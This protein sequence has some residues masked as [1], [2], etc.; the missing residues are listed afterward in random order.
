MIDRNFQIRDIHSVR[1]VGLSQF[2]MESLCI[3]PSDVNKDGQNISTSYRSAKVKPR[4]SVP[5]SCTSTV[6]AAEPQSRRFGST[7]MLSISIY[8]QWFGLKGVKG[9]FHDSE[10]TTEQVQAIK[11]LTAAEKILFIYICWRWTA[12]CSKAVQDFNLW[13]LCQSKALCPLVGIMRVPSPPSQVTLFF[14]RKWEKW[15]DVTPW[16]IS[17]GLEHI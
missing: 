14:V 10:W 8:S 3:R 11:Y 16:L 5:P 2:Y 6:C 7:L 15:I 12:A 9:N 13:P 17:G 4:I 1:L